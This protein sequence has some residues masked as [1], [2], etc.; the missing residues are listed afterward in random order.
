MAAPVDAHLVLKSIV[1]P[2]LLG[3]G[4]PVARY[5]GTFNP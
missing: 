5:F 4:T 2:I 3:L 1:I